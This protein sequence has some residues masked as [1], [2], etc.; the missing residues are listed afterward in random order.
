MA[1]FFMSWHAQLLPEYTLPDGFSIRTYCPGDEAD[2]L[3]CCTGC[4]L[5]VESWTD[6]QFERDMLQRAG[7]TPESI[8]L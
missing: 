4:E 6:G 8:F 2:W 5:G 1:H 3:R 7:I